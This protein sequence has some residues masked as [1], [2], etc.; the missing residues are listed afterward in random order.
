MA[1]EPIAKLLERGDRHRG[2][3]RAR[4]V[5]RAAAAVLVVSVL[6]LILAGLFVRHRVRGSLAQ[7][8]GTL[9]L[10]GLQDTVVVER[11]TRGV[12]TI[13]GSNRS[14]VARATGFVHAQ[15]RFFQMD[16]LRRQ[17]AGELAELLGPALADA[18]TEVR[19][20]RFRA[21]ARAIVAGSDPGTRALLD[22]YSGGVNAGLDRLR[23]KPF[24]YFLLR[25]E[26]EPWSPA[27]TLL[28]VFS[29]YIELQ[30][31]GGRRETALGAIWD[32]MP[33]PLAAFLAT[34][35]TEWDAPVRGG[36]FE[37]PPIPDASIVDLRRR[38]AGRKVRSVARLDH[39][40]AE[41][42]LVAGSNSWAVS[43]EHTA[44]GGALVSNDMHLPLGVPNIW[45]RARLEWRAE[46]GVGSHSVTGVTLPGAPPVVV[47]SNGSVAWSFTNSYGDW[48]D[49]VIVDRDPGDRDRYLTPEGP[50]PFVV[51]EERIEIAGAPVRVVD[52]PWTR[53]GPLVG[54]DHRG[55]ELALRWVAHDPVAVNLSIMELESARTT[56]EALRT[57]AAAGVPAQNFVVGDREGRIAWTILGPLPRRGPCADPQLPSFGARG[58]CEWLGFLDPS[59]YPRIEDP[60]GGRIW[61]ANARVVDGA[62]LERIGDGGYALGARAR[63]IRDGL[64]ALGPTGERDMMELQLD[65]RALFLS[66]WRELLLSTASDSWTRR[67][68]LRESFRSLVRGWGGR[69]S[70]DS[71]GYRLVRGFRI[72]LRDAVFEPIFAQCRQL[73]ERCDHH[74]LSQIEGPLWKLVAERPEH[75]LGPA[76]ESWDALL[77]ATLDDTLEYFTAEGRVLT[78]QTW[79]ARNVV[80]ARHPVSLAV[81]WLSRWLDMPAAS[82]PGDSFMPRTQGPRFGASQRMAVAPGREESGLFHMPGGQSGHPLSPHYEDGHGDWAAGRPSPFLPGP[83]EHVLELEPAA[84]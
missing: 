68:P 51:H 75:L 73:D 42:T 4:S 37:T 18:D 28:V 46:T 65:D 34:R 13:R 33:A 52:V 16:M 57:A 21:S 58:G 71:V 80:R 36:P 45:Y 53:W 66:R 49:V 27:D 81:P 44:H 74:R 6:A 24:E 48:S 61:T 10:P 1:K 29:M 7:L 70:V 23:Q 50:E 26:P 83:A 39:S 56:N 3:R 72:F 32:T 5:V 9:P 60:P 30:D 17:A 19:R 79:G 67:D 63:Q 15:D 38:P 11:D 22:A 25:A 55:R 40:L 35:G 64:A 77:A 14:D 31:E 59:E 82:L 43:G 20:H 8:D 12:P 54:R 84:E 76:H 69:A 2:R 47:G 41:S 78:D 62:A